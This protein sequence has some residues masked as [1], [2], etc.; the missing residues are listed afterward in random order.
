MTLLPMETREV[1]CVYTQYAI[2]WHTLMSKL[3]ILRTTAYTDHAAARVLT[4][5]AYYC[6]H[7]RRALFIGD[8]VTNLFYEPLAL[9]HESLTL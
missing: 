7:H 2:E 4:L 9:V 3:L 8:G 6:P 5:A 1:Q